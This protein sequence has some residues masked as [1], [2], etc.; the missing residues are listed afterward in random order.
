MALVNFL[1]FI[2]KYNKHQFDIPISEQI[3]YLESLGTPNNL[4][5]RSYKQFLCQEYF[6]PWWVRTIW[7]VISFFAIPIV[8]VVFLW[9]GRKLKFESKVETIV[10]DK[11][12]NEIIPEVLTHKYEIQHREWNASSGLSSS[13]IKYIIKKVCGW[14]QPYFVLKSIMQIASYSPRVTRYQP[15]RIIAHQEFS[16]CCSLLTDYCHHRGVKHIDVMHGEKMLYIRDAFFQFDECYVWDMHYANMFIKLKAEPTQFR[17]AVPPSLKID[18]VANQNATAY[19][20]YKYYLAADN[21]DQIKSI[22]ASMAFAKNEGKTVK[23]RI[24]PRYTDLN[25]LKKYVSEDEIEL[26]KEVSILESISN[27]EY[28]IGSFTT[29]LLQSHLSGK[30]VLLDDVTY[31][32]RYSQLKEYGYILA[33]KGLETLSLKQR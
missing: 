10:E 14:R 32:E 1:F 17:V 26:P 2:D 16:F 24:H 4:I 18:T 15:E 3:A 23:Y 25:V 21:E 22:V 13:D 12:M 31:K 30:K 20:D 28:A 8:T 11:G 9:K 5:D 27:M 6:S 29:V 7:F 33:N 19:A